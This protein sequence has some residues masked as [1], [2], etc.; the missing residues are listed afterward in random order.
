MYYDENLEDTRKPKLAG[1]LATEEILYDGYKSGFGSTPSEAVAR[2]WL[3][4][5]NKV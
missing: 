2:L 4:L 5:N 3:T 1:W